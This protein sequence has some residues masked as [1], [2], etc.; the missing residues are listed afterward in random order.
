MIQNG[1]HERTPSP[2][3]TTH[4]YLEGA[5][6]CL[7]WRVVYLMEIFISAENKRT[8]TP[9]GG[10]HG[11]P[12]ASGQISCCSSGIWGKK[13]EGVY[14]R[15]CS[16]KTRN[17]PAGKLPTGC[18]TPKNTSDNWVCE[19][20]VTRMSVKFRLEEVSTSIQVILCFL[21]RWSREG[22]VNNW[23]W[24]KMQCYHILTG[25]EVDDQH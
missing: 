19:D 15:G 6:M 16:L 5:L 14:W 3:E 2:P 11:T 12:P 8:T 22:N 25:V 18:R 9:A 21:T 1:Q 17:K 23:H 10:G 24:W 20:A 4:K 13:E 7:Q